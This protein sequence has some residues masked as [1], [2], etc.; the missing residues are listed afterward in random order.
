MVDNGGARKDLR[1]IH[2][3]CPYIGKLGRCRFTQ[4]RA[5]YIRKND[6]PCPLDLSDADRKEYMRRIRFKR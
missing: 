5:W 1:C 6:E 4:Y 2:D 3:D